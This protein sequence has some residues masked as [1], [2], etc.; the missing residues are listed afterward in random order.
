[1][2]QN[3]ADQLHEHAQTKLDR[4]RA[5]AERSGEAATNPWETDRTPAYHRE[6]RQLHAT[7]GILSALLAIDSRL[8]QLGTHD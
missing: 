8:A 2:S 3:H 6:L 4:C 7:E 5:I 1:M